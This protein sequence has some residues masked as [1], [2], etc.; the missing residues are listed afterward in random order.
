MIQDSLTF[1]TPLL[2]PLLDQFQQQN[3][4]GSPRHEH[5]II[6]YYRIISNLSQ[7]LTAEKEFFESA[8]SEIKRK[9]R[10]Y[11]KFFR[12]DDL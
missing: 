10:G 5:F 9:G 3:V 7:F 12:A 4:M 1:Q 8:I 11:E 2:L 6:D